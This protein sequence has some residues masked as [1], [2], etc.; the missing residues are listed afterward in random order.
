MEGV[1]LHTTRTGGLYRTK[2]W[3][4]ALTK[5]ATSFRCNLGDRTLWA[6]SW[7]E[8]RCHIFRAGGL[9]DWR[10]LDVTKRFKTAQWS[11]GRFLTWWESYIFTAGTTHATGHSIMQLRGSQE[12][13]L[14][15]TRECMQ[16]KLKV[17]RNFLLYDNITFFG[18]LLCTLEFYHCRRWGLLSLT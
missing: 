15:V 13:N 1:N 18:C 11:Q 5:A 9:D 6:S 8:I 3:H 12:E 16:S 4:T 2:R 10:P 17:T 7:I 14:L